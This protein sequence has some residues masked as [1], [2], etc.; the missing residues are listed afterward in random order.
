MRHGA[1]A[2]PTYTRGKLRRPS[3]T[4]AITSQW[5]STQTTYLSSHRT[6]SLGP[7]LPPVVPSGRGDFQP[8]SVILSPSLPSPSL[9]PIWLLAHNPLALRSR[10]SHS[11]FGTG[12]SPWQMCLAFGV[13]IPADPHT[14]PTLLS[15]QMN[16]QINVVSVAVSPAPLRC[17]HHECPHGRLPICQYGA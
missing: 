11:S 12:L 13:T 8:A 7:L 2:N 14:I 3:Q 16:C 6:T 5:S 1:N 10:E 4:L 9:Q 15:A 17:L